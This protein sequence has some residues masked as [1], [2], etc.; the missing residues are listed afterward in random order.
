M[1][2]MREVLVQLYWAAIDAARGERVLR[3]HSSADGDVWRYQGAD[4]ELEIPLPPGSGRIIVAGAGKAVAS[5]GRGLEAMLGD[6]IDA[7]LLIVK[8]GHGFPL[9]RIKVREAAHPVPDAASVE[10]TIA[11]SIRDSTRSRPRSGCATAPTI[12]V[13]RTTPAVASTRAGAAAIL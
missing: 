1:L 8:H 7:G 13:V 2:A 5:P 9:Q 12:P 10:A 11:P 4:G 6:R 3:D